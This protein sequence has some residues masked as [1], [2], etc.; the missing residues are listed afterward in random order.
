MKRLRVTSHS[1]SESPDGTKITF[2]SNSGGSYE[3]YIMNAYGSGQTRL[4]DNPAD[5]EI[6]IW[7]TKLLCDSIATGLD[8]LR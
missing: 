4:T 2:G 8:E 6:S 5:D 7:R 3:I 1:F